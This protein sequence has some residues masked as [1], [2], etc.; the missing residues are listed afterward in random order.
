MYFTIS[1][2]RNKMIIILHSII[3]YYELE[4]GTKL[5]ISFVV[6]IKYR[7]EYQL[8]EWQNDFPKHISWCG[9]QYLR[10]VDQ[11]ICTHYEIALFEST[12]QTSAVSEVWLTHISFCKNDI[13]AT[14]HA[15]RGATFNS[16]NVE[17]I[18]VAAR[19]NKYTPCFLKE[20]ERVYRFVAAFHYST[21]EMLELKCSINQL[22]FQFWH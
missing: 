18:V 21:I 22:L 5:K 6:I 16:P 12:N 1:Y 11:H 3:W 8:V 14:I 2:T 7:W 15:S 17:F 13:S 9:D 10:L 19:L 4:I 20:R